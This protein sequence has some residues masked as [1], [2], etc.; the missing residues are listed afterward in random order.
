M[1]PYYIANVDTLTTVSGKMNLTFYDRLLPPGASYNWGV[2]FLGF[3]VVFGITGNVLVCLAI[4]LEK[5]L[6]TVTNYFL[7]SL[8][9]TDLLVCILVMPMSILNEFF[10]YWRFTALMC[11]VY[12]TTD[13]LMCTSSIFHLCSISVQRYLAI[14]SPLKTRNKSKSIVVTKIGVIWVAAVAISSPVT[15]LGA[16]DQSNILNNHRCNL[17]NYGFIIYGSILAFFIPLIIMV[18]SYTLTVRLLYKQ[19]KLCDPKRQFTKEGMPMIRRCRTSVRRHNSMLDERLI[20]K[21]DTYELFERERTNNNSNSDN[22]TQEIPSAISHSVSCASLYT[23]HVGIKTFDKKES[24]SCFLDVPRLYSADNSTETL[25]A[26]D[27]DVSEDEYSRYRSSFS[28][29]HMPECAGKSSLKSVMTRTFIVKASSLLS[30]TRDKHDKT[31]VRTEQKASKVLGLVFVI[32]VLLWLPFF[33][34]NII[35]ALCIV[36]PVSSTLVSTFA[37]LGWASSTI[38]PIIYTMFN[39]TFKRAFIKLLTCRYHTIAESTCPISKDS[40]RANVIIR[41]N[42]SDREFTL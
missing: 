17:K 33:V 10:G 15:V 26:S 14:R 11:N 12:I 39:K 29:I 36:C 25:T 37:W 34:V 31:T 41:E 8:A 28:N 35:P 19:S 5:R 13:V 42:C 24:K 2:L 32:F 7:L 6:Q 4:S 21:G 22:I 3:V 16:L 40:R 27:L 23:E 38:N 30:L 1:D 20:K 9:V 18:I